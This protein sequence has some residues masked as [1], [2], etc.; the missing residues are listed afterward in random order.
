[1]SAAIGTVHDV[2]VLALRGVRVRRGDK[3][4]LDGID[5]TVHAGEHWALLGPNGAGKSTLLSL[6][7]ALTHP[8][9]GTVE[10]LG[11]RFGR[12]ELQALRRRI[13]HVDPR[14]PLASPLP[15]RDVVLTGL[16]GTVQTLPR[17]EPTA[18]QLSIAEELLESVGLAEK[19]DGRWTILSQGERGRALV[20]RA[21]ISDPELLLLDEPSTGLDIAAREQLLETLEDLSIARPELTTLQVTHHVE[22]LP[23]T[24]T[25]AAMISRGALVA[26]GPVDEVLEGPTASAAFEHPIE[27][28][29]R[30]GRWT[31]RA[32]R[33]VSVP[34]A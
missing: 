4:V 20:A 11:H 24:T 16:T 26:A 13:G 8:T 9:D 14:H 30:N 19:T 15:V 32:P 29:R 27:I 5:L 1:M 33:R 18:V 6:C 21:L 23:T 12:V 28:E 3:A 25:H 10:I 7:G 31:A 22:E 34:G 2:R 17:W